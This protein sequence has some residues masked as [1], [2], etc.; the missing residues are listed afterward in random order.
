M[1]IYVRITLMQRY[2][3]MANAHES[4]CELTLAS[5]FM[6]SPINRLFLDELVGG[7]FMKQHKSYFTKI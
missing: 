6:K 1:Y 3:S 5:Y 7:R 2:A 4:I